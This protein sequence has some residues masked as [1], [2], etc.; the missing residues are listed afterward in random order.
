[1][2]D[3]NPPLFHF[4]PAQ[5]WM[6]DPN[7]LVQH[8]GLHHLFFQHN[9][10]STDFGDIHWGHATSPDLLHWT[11][12]PTALTPGDDGDYDRD[13]CWSGCAVTLPDGKVAVLYSANAAARQL[14]ALAYAQ[15]DELV[16]W[17]KAAENPVIRSWPAL[18][19]L[20]DLRDHT[21]VREGDHWR[22][23]IAAGS[24]STDGGVP[25]QGGCL[26]SYVSDGDDLT[27]WAFDGVL[28]S[29]AESGL[30][31]EVFECPDL[32]VAPGCAEDEVV[33]VFSWYTKRAAGD[34]DVASD[35]LWMTGT[36]EA[37]RFAPRRYGRVDL[38]TRFYAPQSYTTCDGRRVQ[39]GWLRTHEDPASSGRAHRGSQSLPRA[40]TV[41]DGRLHAS[42]A[43]ELDELVH[44]RFGTLP[45]AAP[46]ITVQEPA[47]AL[48]V[49]VTG[50]APSLTA[51]V[52][53]LTSP[54]G[55][56]HKVRLNAFAEPSR[57]TRSGD[58]WVPDD[59]RSQSVRVLVDSGIVEAFTD[60]GRAAA[61]SDLR[62]SSVSQVALHGPAD[63]N[64]EIDALARPNR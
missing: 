51:A 61:T 28:L 32:F 17:K 36:L 25:G 64:A 40:L 27:S 10:W 5:G 15:D 22:Q 1:M 11:Q 50:S 38:G 39:F 14:P 63:L 26:V 8:H 18:E 46:A 45:A 30:P 52:L 47:T 54:S 3:D 43:H 55:Q 56:V 34:G 29:A 7:G 9:P 49:R 58:E 33:L 19:G 4:A 53:V 41:V 2:T 42:P 59:D 60:D 23:V 6:N 35:V 44:T 21:V 12:N 48:D 20:T 57:W 16:T 13:G 37:G 24:D 31:G 62:M